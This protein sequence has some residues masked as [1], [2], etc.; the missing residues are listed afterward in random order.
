MKRN[1]Q[2]TI[3]M[4]KTPAIQVVQMIVAIKRIVVIVKAE[5]VAL[6]LKIATLVRQRKLR[7]QIELAVLQ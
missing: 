5:I 7:H 6:V 3:V 2:K 1:F 4:G